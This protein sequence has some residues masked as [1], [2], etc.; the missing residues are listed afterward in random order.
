[1]ERAL[2]QLRT[3]EDA[4]RFLE[5][6]LNYEKTARWQYNKR[7]LNLGRTRDLLAALGNPH[8]RYS[9]IHV[10]GTKG[11]GTTAGAA[12]RLLTWNGHRTGLLTSPHLITH[13]ERA[14]IDGR[15]ISEEDFLSGIRA[16]QAHVEAERA[17]E[18]RTTV[19]APTYFEMLTALALH[20]FAERGADWAV[21][22]V[23][24]GGRLDSTN[25]VAP[26]CCVV[27]TI[28]FDHVEKLGDTAEAIALEKAGIFK[29]GVPVVLGRQRYPG[30]LDALRRAAEELDCPRWEVGRELRV[31]RAVPLSAP[32]E[33]ATAP[34]GWRFS[35]RTP[36]NDYE[37]VFTPLL[38][39]HQIDNLAAA[40]GA[41]EMTAG[42]SG[43]ELRPE[44]TA[45]ALADFQVPGRMELLQREPAVVLDVAHTVESVEA[46][47]DALETHFPGRPV[48]VV[49]GCSADKNVAGMLAA[50]QGRCVELT[51]TQAKLPRAMPVPEV[52]AAARTAGLVP[53]EGLRSVPDACEAARGAIERADATDVICITGSFFTAGE[54][55][56]RWLEEGAGRA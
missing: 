28:G 40:V 29:Q 19:R 52:V 20:H 23:G 4:V 38:G 2:R 11:K 53:P 7:T 24:L 10:A 13:R 22:E 48:R 31:S 42:H 25:V 36:G 55:R 32:S 54:I 30:A 1:V 50:L 35:L 46:L 9:I 39:R 47:M 26:T 43:M 49:F 56:E 3:Y 18:E 27:T 8:D 33:R 15:D 16:M 34:V 41:V 6:A 14:Q 12:A 17:A 5:E 37:D 21:V 45:A 51:A 44:R